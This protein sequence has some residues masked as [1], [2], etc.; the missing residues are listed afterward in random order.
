LGLEIG[1]HDISH[2]SADTA[3]ENIRAVHRHLWTQ[4]TKLYDELKAIPEG[5][6]TLWD[7]TLILHW[8]EL[9]QGDSHTHADN[10]VVLAGGA[11]GF[12][13]GGRLVDYENEASFSD[14]LVSCFHYMGFDD[15]TEFGDPRLGGTAPLAGIS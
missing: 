13:R 4:S 7:N 9:G 15:V 8:N 1:H 2:D 3:F 5:D 6:G 10:L 11:Q 12:V 14:L